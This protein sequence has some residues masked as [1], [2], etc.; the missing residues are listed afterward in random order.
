[1]SERKPKAWVTILVHVLLVIWL[2]YSIMPFVWTLATSFKQV[3]DAFAVP[4]KFIFE[5]TL[6]AYELLWGRERFPEYLINSA[7]VA[8]STVA[9]SISIGCLAGYGLARYS[10]MS[11]FVILIVALLF[12]SLPRMAFALPYFIIGQWVGLYDTK[13]LLVLVLVT[14]NQPFTI[15]MLRSFF[16]EIPKELEEA[17]MVDGC[18]RL[19]AFVR[20]IM[21]LMGPGIVTASIFSLLLAY[22]EYLLAAMVTATNARTL[23]VVIAQFGVAEDLQAWTIT[24]A[25]GVSVALPIVL[26][27]LF[28]QKYVVRGLT[29]GAVKG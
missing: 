14:V 13:L 27:V 28:A 25:A 10:G 18:S 4:P 3:V 26:V 6:D 24:A 7:I 2:I 23:P 1:M 20:V 15:W 9:I 19:S 22:N 12:R 16:M 17:A 29:F 5:P 8:F 21:P 11:G